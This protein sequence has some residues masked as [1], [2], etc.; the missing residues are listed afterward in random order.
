MPTHKSKEKY[1]YTFARPTQCSQLPLL[2]QEKMHSKIGKHDERAAID[3]QPNAILPQR[4]HVEAKAAQNR[5][6]RNLNVQAVFVIDER[7][8][9]D[10]VDNQAFKGI[11]EYR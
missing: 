8:V 2:H 1:N 11:V 3:A 5:G 7:E 10:F 4:L 9:L 6:A